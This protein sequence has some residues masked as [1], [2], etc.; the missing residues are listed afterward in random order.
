[1]HLN[2]LRF[3][4]NKLAAD[5]FLPVSGGDSV[6]VNSNVKKSE[7]GRSLWLNVFGAVTHVSC[8]VSGKGDGSNPKYGGSNER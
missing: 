6:N 4:L 7:R 3:F 5:H 1:M 2:T 8:A